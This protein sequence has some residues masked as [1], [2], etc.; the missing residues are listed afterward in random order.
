MI[1]IEWRRGRTVVWLLGLAVSIRPVMASVCSIIVGCDRM[2]GQPSA[3]VGG[4]ERG[5]AA[6]ANEVRMSATGGEQCDR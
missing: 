6:H 2:G 5:I 3:R 4:M 1:A